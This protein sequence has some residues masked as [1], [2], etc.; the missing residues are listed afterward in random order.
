MINIYNFYV[1][2]SID[3]KTERK[4]RVLLKKRKLAKTKYL[5]LSFIKQ[6]LKKLLNIALIFSLVLS[7]IGVST[8]KVYCVSM[9]KV[10]EKSCCGN[11]DKNDGCCKEI[12]KMNKLTTDLSS[13]NASVEIPNVLLLAAIVLSYFDFTYAV[14]D[15]A[16]AYSSYSPPLIT[17]DITVLHQ[18]FRI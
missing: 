2:L 8:S 16:H 17:L 5:K 18:L 13:V 9:N 6:M 3:I 11:K 1:C 7:I 15:K 10:M 14:P 4:K 12:I